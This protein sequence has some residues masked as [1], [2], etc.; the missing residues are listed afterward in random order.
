MT[1]H[2]CI[3][4]RDSTVNLISS[5]PSCK[6]DNTRFTIVP[7][8]SIWLIMFFKFKRVISRDPRCKHGNSRF[9]KVSLKVLL[10]FWKLIIFNLGFNALKITLIHPFYLYI[11]KLFIYI[12]V[13]ML[14]IINGQTAGPNG[15]KFF[16]GTLEYRGVT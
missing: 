14:A 8:K 7:L 9:K 10:K 4:L 16:E 12:F 3:S 2:Q 5:K 15:L 13:C 11:I 6:D 1:F